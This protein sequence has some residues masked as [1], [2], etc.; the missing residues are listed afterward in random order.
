[1]QGWKFGIRASPRVKGLVVNRTSI[2]DGHVMWESDLEERLEVAWI[3]V[4]TVGT[5]CFTK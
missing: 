5:S 2:K 4:P 1:M 3:P